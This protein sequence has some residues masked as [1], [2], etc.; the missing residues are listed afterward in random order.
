MKAEVYKIFNDI[1]TRTN[2]NENLENF[3]HIFEKNQVKNF[4]EVLENI[5]LIIF[6]NYDKNN[7]VLKNIKE[8]IKS[9][10]EKVVKS[11]KVKENTKKLINYFCKL[12]T[13]GVKKPK[14]KTLCIYFLSK[15]NLIL[16]IYLL[17]S[18]NRYLP[19]SLLQQLRELLRVRHF[20]RNQKLH[21][22]HFEE[23]TNFSSLRRAK[24]TTEA[25]NPSERQ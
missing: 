13:N 17:F 12:F 16:L 11:A 24:I 2:T 10:L 23:Q 9:F 6:K 4:Q 14:Y 3:V 1:Q 22:E 5:F 25:H 15:K 18:L 7:V 19:Y 8:F 20:G 21:F